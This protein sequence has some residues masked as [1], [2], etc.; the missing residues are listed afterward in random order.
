MAHEAGHAR[1]HDPLQHMIL[2]ILAVGLSPLGFHALYRRYLIHREIRADIWAIA[3][4]NGDDLPLLQALTTILRDAAPH[5][6]PVGLA[7]A[8]EYRLQFLASRTWPSWWDHDL[9]VRLACSAL[10]VLLAVSESLAV[11]CH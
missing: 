11:W 3:S 8:F 10:A 1:M 4:C 7:G 6:S 9:K 5:P 2:S